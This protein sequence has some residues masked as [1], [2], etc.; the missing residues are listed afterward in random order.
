MAKIEDFESALNKIDVATDNIAED[1]RAL[2][3]ELTNVGLPADVEDSVLARLEATAQ[4][5]EAIAAETPEEGEEPVE[6]EE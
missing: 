5:L 2:K 6:D 4:K 3:E 1:L